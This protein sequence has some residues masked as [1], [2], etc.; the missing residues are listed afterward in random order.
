MNKTV[1]EAPVLTEGLFEDSLCGE[2]KRAQLIALGY[3]TKD[4]EALK[5]LVNR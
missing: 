1:K 5:E 3:S 4:L 2:V